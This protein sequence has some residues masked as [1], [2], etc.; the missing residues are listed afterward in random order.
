MKKNDQNTAYQ[1]LHLKVF[2]V[3]WTPYGG[4]ELIN[5]SLWKLIFIYRVK[6]LFALDIIMMI[7]SH[8]NFAHVTTAQLSG[9][10]Q[11]CDPIA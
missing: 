3:A 9:H 1:R 4:Y 11:N 8:H 6:I 7:Q 5:E 2:S 10:V